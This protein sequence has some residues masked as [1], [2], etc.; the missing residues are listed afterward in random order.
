MVIALLA[1]EIVLYLAITD[2]IDA[3]ALVRRTLEFHPHLAK[4]GMLA[5]VYNYIRAKLKHV[6]IQYQASVVW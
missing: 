1:P 4:P 6:S 5:R 3:T 2:R